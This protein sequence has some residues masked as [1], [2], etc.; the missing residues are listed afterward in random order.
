MPW[1]VMKSAAFLTFPEE[2][3]FLK[4]GTAPSPFIHTADLKGFAAASFS[5]GAF[6]SGA[7]G[8]AGFFLNILN[9]SVQPFTN[10]PFFLIFHTFH[11]R[12]TSAPLIPFL[13]Y[14]PYY[15]FTVFGSS[16]LYNR[17][18]GLYLQNQK[19]SPEHPSMLCIFIQD[20]DIIYWPPH[21][22]LSIVQRKL[23]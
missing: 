7:A 19:N 2:K 18:N 6:S 15:Y 17:A 10:V 3:T 23:K 21:D 9:G 1:A 11:L 16:C 20:R 4:A 13:I 5:F 22:G 8:S 14:H 12:G